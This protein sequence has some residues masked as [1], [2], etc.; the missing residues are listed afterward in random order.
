MQQRAAAADQGWSRHGPAAAHAELQRPMPNRRR[1]ADSQRRQ[2]WDWTQASCKPRPSHCRTAVILDATGALASDG[3]PHGRLLLLGGI[4]LVD[5]LERLL[6]AG[7]GGGCH[8]AGAHAPG[9]PLRQGVGKTQLELA[10]LRSRHRNP[11]PLCKA[12]TPCTPCMRACARRHTHKRAPSRA[13]RSSTTRPRRRCQGYSSSLSRPGW[14]SRR[15]HTP[16]AGGVEEA[17]GQME[18]RKA[19]GGGMSSQSTRDLLGAGRPI[20]AGHAAQRAP[21]AQQRQRAPSAWRQL[22]GAPPATMHATDGGTLGAP[23]S[24]ESGRPLRRCGTCRWSRC[25]RIRPCWRCC[26]RS[27]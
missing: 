1:R 2:L 21:H 5:R 15:P 17:G 6:V 16:S 26:T 19:A 12:H 23:P 8:A 9:A 22:Q 4:R 7:L 27:G 24:P 11:K 18:G 13:G 3:G 10:K 20:A 14:G 25:R